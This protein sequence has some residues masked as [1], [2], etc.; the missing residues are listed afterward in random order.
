MPLAPFR[1]ILIGKQI[2]HVW[3]GFGSALFLEFGELS[4]IVFCQDGSTRNPTGEISLMIEW[5]WRIEKPRSILGG[6]WSSDGKWPGM[7]KKLLGSTV[8]DVSISTGLPE[9]IL[10]L[11]SGLKLKSFMTAEGQPTWTIITRSP[12]LGTLQVKRGS[13]FVEATPNTSFKHGQ[14]KLA[15]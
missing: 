6:S 1:E 14:L 7:F 13:L 11:S 12:N 2:S 9:L 5:S 4:D 15:P 10:M 3:R 8:V